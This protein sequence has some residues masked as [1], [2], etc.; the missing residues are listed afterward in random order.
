MDGLEPL[1]LLADGQ[2]VGHV[3][4]VAAPVGPHPHYMLQHTLTYHLFE[5]GMEDLGRGFLGGN[6][7]IIKYL[8]ETKKQKREYFL[9]ALGEN[10]FFDF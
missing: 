3:G 8:D 1:D 5:W 4:D 9:S 6:R 10:N 7:E 2:G